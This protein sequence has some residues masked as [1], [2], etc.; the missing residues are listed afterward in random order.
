MVRVISGIGALALM[1]TLGVTLLGERPA[2]AG[3]GFGMSFNCVPSGTGFNCYGSLRAARLSAGA[4][5]E[6][7][8][9]ITT[10]GTAS[11][12]ATFSGSN[13]A[14]SFGSTASSRIAPVIA[15]D[16][17]MYFNLTMDNAGTC[18]SAY[19]ENDS[20]YQALAHP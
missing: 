1:V 19:F 6:A 5:D 7:R 4:T 8:F 11:F 10:S 17:N 15:G 20:A 18:T 2:A 16:Y 13:Y 14:C 12:F 9:R 3:Q